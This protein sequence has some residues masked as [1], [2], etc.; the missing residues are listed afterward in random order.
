[1]R[2]DTFPNGITFLPSTELS[3]FIENDDLG[4]INLTLTTSHGDDPVYKVGEKLELVIRTNKEAWLYCYYRQANGE[5][6]QIFPNP[7]YYK[8]F[9]EPRIKGGVVY[10]IPGEGLF[11]FALEVKEPAG[12]EIAKCFVVNRDITAQLPKELGGH[13]LEVIDPDLVGKLSTIF[14]ELA[15][16]AISEGSVVIT[17]ISAD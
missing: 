5:T 17:V 7:Y 4:P 14:R 2:R 9:D 13:S 15:G 1:M 8:D 6:L 11:P 16:T 3:G 12:I 10:V